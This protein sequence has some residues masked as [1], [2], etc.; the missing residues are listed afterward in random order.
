MKKRTIAAL[1]IGT[2]KIAVVI[3]EKDNNGQLRILAHGS[4]PSY[5]VNRGAVFNIDK[6][7]R[8]IRRA[9]DKA[10]LHYGKHIDEVYVGIAGMH[11]NSMQV[12]RRL[13]RNNHTGVTAEELQNMRDD[14]ARQPVNDGD[15]IIHVIPQEF[16]ADDIGEAF[17]KE[18]VQG[19]SCK[20]L[21]GNYHIITASK[22]AV[23]NI[24]D[25]VEQAGLKILSEP[26][27]EPL[28]SAAATIEQKLC[29]TGVAMVDIGGG[30]TDIA[31][32]QGKVLRHT[33]VIPIAGNLIS[34]DI[35]KL[36]KI[37]PE[38]ANILKEK[39]GSAIDNTAHYEEIIIP[40]N[41]GMREVKVASTD[42]AGVIRARVEQ[43][44]DAVNEELE[45]SGFK[46]KLLSGIV[47][48]GGGANLKSINNLCE[49][50]TSLHTSLGSPVTHFSPI[51]DEEL[52]LSMANPIYSTVIGL[53]LL[54]FSYQ[55]DVEAAEEEE[56]PTKVDT[57]NKII[58]EIKEVGERDNTDSGTTTVSVTPKTPQIEKD[59][60][61]M[62]KLPFF[63]KIIENL[64]EKSDNFLKEESTIVE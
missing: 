31:I 41:Y 42:L 12:Q 9:V 21:V 35:E 46:H 19:T 34:K 27:L 11:I 2:T 37:M 58:E 16:F 1:D 45:K 22:Q 50:Q 36:F 29:E 54:G 48:T 18:D 40:A 51:N 24:I 49:H 39:F 15:R 4:E 55:L 17:T 25:S 20:V 33:A 63:S 3:A 64:K 26:I 44:F 28:A 14:A 61:S 38:T 53:A 10:E 30:T 47:I 56:I 52:M 5:G 6:T 8:A 7:A 60:F 62:F 43:I 32:Y 57:V 59:R 23:K 13:N